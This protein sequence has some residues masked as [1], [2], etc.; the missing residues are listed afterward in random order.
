ML[1]GGKGGR[2]YLRCAMPPSPKPLTTADAERLAAALFGRTATAT[3]LNGEF[4]DN[5]LLTVA[6]QPDSVLKVS[7]PATRHAFLELEVEVLAQLGRAPSSGAFQFPTLLPTT[8]GVTLTTVPEGC[9]GAGRFVRRFTYIPGTHLA[10]LMPCAPSLLTSLG[11]LLATVDQALL[12]LDH[13]AALRR[14]ADEGGEG[15]RWALADTLWVRDAVHHVTDGRRR[16]VVTR[17]LDRVERE[18]LPLLPALRQSIIHGD[19]SEYN[20]LVHD[21][22]AVSLVDFGDLHRTATV[23]ELAVGAAYAMFGAGDPLGAAAHVVAGY[24][25]VLPLT[26]LERLALFPLILARLAVSVVNSALRHAHQPDDAYITVSAA[27]AWAILDQVADVPGHIAERVLFAQSDALAGLPSRDALR[28]VRQRSL[29]PSLSLSYRDPLYLVRGWKQYLY[30]ADG[31]EYIDAYNNV[32]HVG[33]VHP[34]VVDAIARQ[35]AL[36]NTNTRYLHHLIGEYAE[37]LTAL[38]PAPLQV[39]YFVNSG[40]EANELALRLARTHTRQRDVIVSTAAYHG[41]TQTLVDVS[42]YKYNGAGGEGRPPWVHE[43][44]LPDVY[45]GPYRADDPGA[46][47][48]YAAHVRESVQAI[49]AAGRGLCA[50]LFESLPSVGG[51]IIPPQGYLTA[52]YEAVRAAGGIC[53]ADEVQVGLGRVGTHTWGFELQGVVPDIVTCGKPIGNGH[54]LGAVI[55]TPEIAASFAN[56]MEYFNT[57]GG[58]PVSMAAGLAVLDVLAEEGLQQ[59][60]L[61]VGTQLLT[62]LR[63]FTERH[64]LVGDVRGAG[65]FIGVELVRDRTTLNPADTEAAAVV[66]ALRDR[67]ILTGTDGPYHNVIKIRPPMPFDAG[68]AERLVAMLDEVL[69]QQHQIR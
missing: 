5:F 18:A 60:A 63:P 39:C 30:D 57:F 27:P 48:K 28:T 6:R 32:V 49:R 3:R 42:P 20:V 50:F 31:T 46:G 65:L 45:R 11:A 17:V 59:H 13:P 22:R 53:I 24:H 37:R 16:G 25:R 7:H 33:H 14:R 4:D 58:N 26:A 35:A 51:Q 12:G 2:M 21:G 34:R 68:N 43:V 29:G 10:D 23:G 38:L 44:P 15:F 47:A 55:T 9:P 1:V 19:A 56:G 36:L 64:A 40:S 67:R 52:A 8:T 54:P 62:M 69:P 41:N 61:E 66:D